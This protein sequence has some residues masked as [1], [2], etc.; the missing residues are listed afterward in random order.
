MLMYVQDY[1]DKMPLAETWADGLFPYLENE[2]LFRCPQL[3]HDQEWPGSDYAFNSALAGRNLEKFDNPAK[4]AV[5]FDSSAG[6]AADGTLN[7]S[8]SL[9]SFEARH[10]SMGNIAYADGYVGARQT[11]PDPKAGLTATEDDKESE[12]E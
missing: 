2:Y 7:V 1:D 12:T 8:D 3:E 11:A 5:F 6:L 9:A 4:V 10:Q